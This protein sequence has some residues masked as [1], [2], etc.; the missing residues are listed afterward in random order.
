MQ[1]LIEPG[2]TILVVDWFGAAFC[3][4]KDGG[5]LVGIEPPEFELLRENGGIFV[6]PFQL[7]IIIVYESL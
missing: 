3:G 6:L 7:M 2:L 1:F 4:V 5:G